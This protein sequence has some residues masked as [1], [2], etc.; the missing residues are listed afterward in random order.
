MSAGGES[1]RLGR[2]LEALFGDGLGAGTADGRAMRTVPIGS[3][4]ANP[5]QPRRVFGE[6]ELADLVRSVRDKGVLQPLIVRPSAGG[7]DVFEIVAG[8]RRWR[9]AQQAGVHEVPVVIRSLGDEETLAVA[10]VENLQRDDLS[11]I[12]E[13]EAYERL[14][15]EFGKTQAEVAAIVG[16]SRPHVANTL[17]LLELPDE[18]RAMV[19]GGTLTAGHARAI[20]GTPDPVAMAREIVAGNL[21]VRATEERVAD[22]NRRGR[23]AGRRRA[24]AARDADT[25]ALEKRL[26]DRLGLR[27]SIAARGAG[28]KL[29]LS[30]RSLEQLDD[31][32]ARLS[33]DRPAAR[34]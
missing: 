30:Y 29:T 2:G 16:K 25:V 22:E 17:R 20:L 32:I 12:E 21:S 33:V 15:R 4:V 6:A 26:G 14:A 1:R 34:P 27:V 10:L 31:L 13:A 18:I 5:L 8:E 11:P 23:G 3:L 28:G 19:A 7:P 24:A 9:A